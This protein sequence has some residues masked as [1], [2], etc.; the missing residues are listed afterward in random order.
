MA[1]LKAH[2]DGKVLVLDEAADLPVNCPLEVQVS[3]IRTPK[4]AGK[5]LARLATRLASIPGN[6]Q[7]RL[8]P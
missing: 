7:H 2:F 4:V 8:S 5:P 3:P 6:A 1:K